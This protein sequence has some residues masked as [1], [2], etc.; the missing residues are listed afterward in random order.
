MLTELE[1]LEATGA[2]TPDNCEMLVELHELLDKL[3]TM[4]LERPRQNLASVRPS[5]LA[6]AAADGVPSLRRGEF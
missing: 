1:H 6:A 2:A 4:M 3:Y 5:R